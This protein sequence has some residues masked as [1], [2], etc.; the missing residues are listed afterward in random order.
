MTT[1]RELHER[2]RPFVIP[3][4]WD[5]G[6]ARILKSLGFEALATTSAG[7][8]FAAGVVEGVLDLDA[9]LDHCRLIVD[10]TDLPVSAD[11]ENGYGHTPEEVAETI[12]RAGQVGLSGGSIEDYTG[13]PSSPIYDQG[14]AVER[15]AAAVEAARSLPGDFVLTARCEKFSYGQEDLDA[16]IE[17]LAAYADAGADAIYAPELPGL[18]GIRTVTDAIDCPLNVVMGMPGPVYSIDELADAGVK[19][20]SIGS[21]MFRLAYGSLL[22]A[23][24]EIQEKGTFTYSHDAVGFSALNEIFVGYSDREEGT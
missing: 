23:G 12:R 3:N 18:E 7:M 13:D 2:D 6:S 17:R 20:I 11:L 14:L 15:I 22:H 4:P 1:F 8:D 19:R 5:V 9:V 24:R 16:V 10:A 21:A